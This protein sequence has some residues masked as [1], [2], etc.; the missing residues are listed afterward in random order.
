MQNSSPPILSILILLLLSSLPE[1]SLQQ[2]TQE[3]CLR[4]NQA[5]QCLVCKEYYILEEDGSCTLESIYNSR[6]IPSVNFGP[7]IENKVDPI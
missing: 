1:P 7:F 3:G 2:I 5:N 4:Q 6:N